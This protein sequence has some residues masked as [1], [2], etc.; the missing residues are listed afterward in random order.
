[1][2]SL[3]LSVSLTSVAVS[4]LI[5]ILPKGKTSVTIKAVAGFLITFVILQAVTN[6]DVS[7]ALSKRVFGDGEINY[8]QDYLFFI[9]E[10][11]KIFLKKKIIVILEKN[12]IK[13]D[14]EELNILTERNGEEYKIE[15][16][17]VDLSRAVIS[18]EIEHINI[19]EEITAIVSESA[20][21]SR[22]SVIVYGS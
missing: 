1:M 14:E 2:K 16:I 8:Q 9:T 20:G 10:Q 12:G 15:K 5:F 22:E 6:I 4:I 13:I 11:R 17:T 21:I 7:S 19:K 3:L 18:E